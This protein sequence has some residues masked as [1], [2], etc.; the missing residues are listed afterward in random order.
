MLIAGAG[1]VGLALANDLGQRSIACRLIERSAA[2]V[3]LPKMNFVNVR[4]MELCRRWGL[5]HEVRKAGWPD[6]HP[7]DVAYV[8]SLCGHEIARF[9]YP[10]QRNKRV[11]YSPEPSQRCPQIWFDPI[12]ERGLQRF[13][14]VELLRGHELVRFDEDG[15]LIVAC[16]RELATGAETEQIAS[17]LVGA[18]GAGSRVR[19]LAGIERQSWGPAPE[20]VA[21]A[22]RTRDARSVIRHERAAFFWVIDGQGLRGLVTPTDGEEMWRFNWNLRRGETPEGFDADAAVRTL[23]GTDFEYEILTVM[24]WRIR[25]TLAERYRK[26]RVFLAGDAA[27]TLSPTGGLGMNTGLADA[28]DLGWKLA[29]VLEGWGGERLLESYDLERRPTGRLINEESLRNL[30]RIAGIPRLAGIAASDEGGEKL[31]RE[32]RDVL[33]AGEFR[34]EFEND[35]TALGLQYTESPCIEAEGAA[36]PHDPNRYT[37]FCLAGCRA[38]HVELPGGRSTLDLYGRGFCLL[39]LGEDAPET[40]ALTRLASSR[41]VPLDVEHL[42]D[43]EILALHGRALVLVRPDGVV[44]WRGDRLPEDLGAWLDR[45][46]GAA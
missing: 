17:F 39:R 32:A 46:R 22:L 13:D 11:A 42:Q 43:P 10:A 37:S 9:R 7:L 44:A 21:I 30:G 27:R 3:A 28:A 14:H 20:Q 38:P 15:D 18:D 36:P 24:P 2:P 5:A 26:G 41:G 45:A 25:F 29:A 34:L 6:A 8:T 40:S 12:L 23:A 1:P 35:G 33:E 16:V 31:R 4:S 19:E